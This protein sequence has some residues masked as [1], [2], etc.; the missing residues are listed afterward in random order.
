MKQQRQDEIDKFRKEHRKII[1]YYRQEEV[2]T[3]EVSD[4]RGEWQI[5]SHFGSSLI[6]GKHFWLWRF[7]A[8]KTFLF[9][10][11]ALSLPSSGS[12]ASANPC[13]QGGAAPDRPWGEDQCRRCRGSQGAR[14]V[15]CLVQDAIEWSGIRCLEL[16]VS[17]F[18][19]RLTISRAVPRQRRQ[20]WR[21]LPQFVQRNMRTSKNRKRN[22]WTWSTRWEGRSPSSKR[23]RKE[24]LRWCNCRGRAASSRLLVVMMQASSIN[25]A[26]RH[27]TDGAGAQFKEFW[28]YGRHRRRG[29][30]CCVCV[31]ESQAGPAWRLWRT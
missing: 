31:Q 29:R 17:L 25:S 7:P 8:M 27:Q 4:K 11:A 15:R 23:R 14:R 30:S 18:R 2:K 26:R 24:D 3:N 6:T 20:T 12:A 28:C 21:P 10:F 13:E 1:N 19:P 16:Q 22:C 5:C 9:G